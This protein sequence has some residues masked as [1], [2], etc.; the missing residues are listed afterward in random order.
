[1]DWTQVTIA[2]LTGLFGG[3]GIATIIRAYRE[4]DKMKE[5]DALRV[6]IQQLRAEIAIQKADC[7]KQMFQLNNR[8]ALQ[9]RQLRE[10][11]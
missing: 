8:F 1:M 5:M 6:E 10:N 3:G 9:I 11:L 7:E 2:L 4:T